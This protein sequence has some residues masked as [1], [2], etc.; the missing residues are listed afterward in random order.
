M[1]TPQ[2]FINVGYK[3]FENVKH[4][5]SYA[6]YGLQK[7]ISDKKGKRYYITVYVYDNRKL[8]EQRPELLMTDFSFEP[9]VQFC[10][11]L[12]INIQF[13]IKEETSIEQIEYM[14]H[15]MWV[16]AGKPYYELWN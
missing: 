15:R 12:T 9:D 2:D 4:I 13:G 5:R 3:R 1:L 6:D 7:L 8:K 11:D 16:T 14:F 10:T